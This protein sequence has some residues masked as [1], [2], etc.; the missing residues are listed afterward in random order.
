M[1]ETPFVVDLYINGDSLPWGGFKMSGI[2][3]NNT[4]LAVEHYLE[5]K[6]MFIDAQHGPTRPYYRVVLGG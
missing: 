5:L 1:V 6:G 2:G 4:V 3:R